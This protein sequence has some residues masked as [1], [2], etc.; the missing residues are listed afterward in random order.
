MKKRT[1]LVPLVGLLCGGCGSIKPVTPDASPEAVALL[2][3]IQG[4]SGKYTLT[5]Q[6]NYPNTKDASTQWATRTCGQD[7]GHFRPGFRLRQPGD[8]DAVA[9]RPGII[10]E[11]KRQYEQGSIITLCWH[12]VPPTADEPV[13]FRPKPGAR[14]TG[15]PACRAGSR[16]NSG[17]T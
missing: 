2:N 11:V 16:M 4:I 17:T 13:T 3:Y 7:P 9:A 10:A 1:M 5:G 14:R 12:A 8:K 6:H 15:S